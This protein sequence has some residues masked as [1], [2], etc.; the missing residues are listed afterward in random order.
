MKLSDESK[1]RIDEMLGELNEAESAYAKECLGGMKAEAKED[2]MED[3]DT[4]SLD[5][6]EMFVKTKGKKQKPVAKVE[7]EVEKSDDEDEGMG[8]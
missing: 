4:I 6:E 3:E 8:Y 5:G 2:M 1:A 7:V